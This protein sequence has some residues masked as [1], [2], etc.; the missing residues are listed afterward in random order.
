VDNLVNLSCNG[1]Q[2][3]SASRVAVTTI[4]GRS[5]GPGSDHAC[6]SDGQFGELVAQAAVYPRRCMV[7]MLEAATWLR[8]RA[9][10][11]TSRSAALRERRQRRGDAA[12]RH[13]RRAREWATD[14]WSTEKSS[15]NVKTLR[16]PET[17][18]KEVEIR[19]ARN[20]RPP[21]MG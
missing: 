11:G 2:P 13:I 7:N 16:R 4:S 9:I 3:A 20:S 1:S 18:W 10:G 21:V 15:E 8:Q 12:A 19:R 6:G 14:L 5:P 17:S